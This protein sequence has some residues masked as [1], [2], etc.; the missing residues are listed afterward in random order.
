[1]VHFCLVF[2]VQIIILFLLSSIV[3]LDACWQGTRDAQGTIH[4][5][6]ALFPNGIAP[7]V[8]YVHSRKLKFGIYSG[9]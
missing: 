8:D 1:M 9:V 7:L 6:P 5:D 2:Y 4:S 3:N